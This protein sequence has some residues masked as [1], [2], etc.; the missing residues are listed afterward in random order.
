MTCQLFWEV[1]LGCDCIEG[2]L[3]GSTALSMPHAVSPAEC[4]GGANLLY[5]HSFAF[6]YRNI[7]YMLAA[8]LLMMM[9]VRIAFSA[10]TVAAAST[11][12]PPP[13]LPPPQPPV[14]HPSTCLDS[15]CAVDMQVSFS[16][17]CVGPAAAT[18]AA[19][20]CKR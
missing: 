19:P 4:A 16:S 1:W 17:L 14:A 11:P 2:S 18:R 3:H 7:L 13:P 10:A 6:K 12:T 8:V 20:C 9:L 5:L 15:D